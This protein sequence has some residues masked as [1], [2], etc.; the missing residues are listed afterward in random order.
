M[1]QA[2]HVR[3]FKTGTHGE[4]LGGGNAHHGVGKRSV[5]L[6]KN[7]ITQSGRAAAHHA[8]D[9]AAQGVSGVTSFLD[10]SDHGFRSGGSAVRTMLLSMAEAVT[11]PQSTEAFTW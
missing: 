8:F 6:V 3:R 9:H 1:F 5:Q 2:G 11:A 4:S 10:G 7:R